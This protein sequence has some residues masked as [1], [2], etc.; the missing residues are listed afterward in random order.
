M[1]NCGLRVINGNRRCG[2]VSG[3]PMDMMRQYRNL[4][5]NWTDNSRGLA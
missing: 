4:Y 5:F 1:V 3:I 2:L